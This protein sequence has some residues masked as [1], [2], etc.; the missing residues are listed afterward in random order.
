MMQELDDFRD[1][2]DGHLFLQPLLRTLWLYRRTMQL[3]F[4]VAVICCVVAAVF[5][6]AWAPRERIAS[7]GFQLAFEGADRGE[8]PNGTKFS[9]AE[10]VSTPVLSEVFKAN[11][12]QRYTAF[13][14]F[15]DAV[16]VLQTNRDLELLSYEYTAKLS[17]SKLGPVDRARLEEEFRKKRESLGSAGFSLNIRRN[18]TLLTMPDAMLSEDYIIS[19]DLLRTKIER[20]LKSVVVMSEIPGHRRCA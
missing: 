12:L 5:A 19:V 20:I 1:E 17:D 13:A 10:M 6:Y 4:A 14:K 15:K 18:E 8:Y 16:F 9:S 3:A 11:D 7:L 2:V